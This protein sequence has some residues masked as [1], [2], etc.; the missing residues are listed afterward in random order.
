[1]KKK[2]LLSIVLLLITVVAFSQDLKKLTLNDTLTVKARLIYSE[3]FADNLSKWVKEIEPSISSEV[4]IK[5]GKLDIDVGAGCSVWFKEKMEGKILIEFDAVMV[6]EGGT[7]DN[8]QDLNSYWMANDPKNPDNIFKESEARGGMYRSYFPLSLYYVGLGET[9]NRRSRL[10][11]YDGSGKR[12][13]LPDHDLT[14][15]EFLLRGNQLYQ[16][17]II[18]FGNLIQYYRNEELLFELNDPAA[19][20]SGY[21]CFRTVKSHL[22]IDDFKVYQL[23]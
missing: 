23:E 19:F 15:S 14:E 2:S 16:I 6:S 22:T 20:T 7:N 4:S 12:P 21:F 1:M 9:Q 5:E 17:K 3:N 8:V 18:A 13:W 10:R 11:R